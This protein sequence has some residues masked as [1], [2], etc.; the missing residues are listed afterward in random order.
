MNHINL[1]NN[2]IS[3]DIVNVI[4]LRNL[5][6]FGKI[7]DFDLFFFSLY[8][9]YFKYSADFVRCLYIYFMVYFEN[10]DF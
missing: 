4:L 9:V 6:I 8:F 10:I 7:I 1:N 3:N 5:S 2:H